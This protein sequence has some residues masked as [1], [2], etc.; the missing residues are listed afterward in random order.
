MNL[1]NTQKLLLLAIKI[2]AP[3]D[4][5]ELAEL[6][7]VTPRFIQKGLKTLREAELAVKINEFY[8]LTDIGKTIVKCLRNF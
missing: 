5:N 4:S 8:Y 2:E 1:T 6:F 7:E 3:V